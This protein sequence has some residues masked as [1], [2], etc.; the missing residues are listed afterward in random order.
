MF[1]SKSHNSSCWASMISNS[2]NCFFNNRRRWFHSKHMDVM[3]WQS[4][5]LIVRVAMPSVVWIYGWKCL[6]REILLNYEKGIWNKYLFWSYLF[7]ICLEWSGLKPGF[8][9]SGSHWRRRSAPT[10]V[11]IS[12]QT[13]PVINCGRVYDNVP[14]LEGHLKRCSMFITLQRSKCYF[15]NLL[16]LFFYLKFL[17]IGLI[18]HPVTPPSHWRAAHLLLFMPAWPVPTTLAPRYPGEIMW[19][20]RLSYIFYILILLWGVIIIYFLGILKGSYHNLF[21]W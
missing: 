14:L 11:R 20:L 8:I 16:G 9:N 4:V 10:P 2:Q 21:Y 19:N 18:I 15:Q 12:P 17:S 7:G 13:C 3:S 1:L 6:V 5:V